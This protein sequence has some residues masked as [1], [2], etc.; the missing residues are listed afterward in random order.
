MIIKSMQAKVKVR[1]NSIQKKN[2]FHIL[3]NIQNLLFTVK[4][5]FFAPHN[6]RWNNRSSRC[7]AKVYVIRPNQAEF[8][9]LI[10]MF[11]LL[12]L[13]PVTFCSALPYPH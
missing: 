5:S 12:Q 2:F 8:F 4:I 10:Q 9:N 1:W 13:A 6:L 3:Q 11:P 7:T